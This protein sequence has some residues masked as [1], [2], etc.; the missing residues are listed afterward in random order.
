MTVLAG[1]IRGAST[2]NAEWQP[3]DG[4]VHYV[5]STPTPTGLPRPAV[6]TGGYGDRRD[7]LRRVGRKNYSLI[8]LGPLGW[9]FKVPT[10]AG[11]F[12][13]TCDDSADT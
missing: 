2:A 12:V 8:G 1:T 9:R 4:K 13:K 3:C 11:N 10:I 6:G 7:Y 5:L